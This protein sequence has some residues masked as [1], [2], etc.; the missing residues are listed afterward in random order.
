MSNVCSVWRASG[1]RALLG[2]GLI[3]STFG[4][5]PPVEAQEGQRPPQVAP[6]STQKPATAPTQAPAA[7]SPAANTARTEIR[8]IEAWTVTCNFGAD[9]A[10]TGCS[11]VLRVTQRDTNRV[12][13]VWTLARAND[14]RLFAR[15]D[16][17][18]GV[19]I[20]PGVELKFTSGAPRR[21]PYVACQPSGCVA[22]GPMDDAFIRQATASTSI[23]TVVQG[24][25]GRAYNFTF[26]PTGINQAIDLVRR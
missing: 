11:A 23:E 15:I 4:T 9:G 18:P 3:I 14:G 10:R 21:L 5:V 17:L 13:L 16:T 8:T 22:E 24:A 19:L 26:A 25:D 6:R 7:T 2:F 20:T 1:L 12:V